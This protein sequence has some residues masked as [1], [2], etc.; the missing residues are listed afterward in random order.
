MPHTQ[1]DFR[2]CIFCRNHTFKRKTLADTPIEFTSHLQDASAEE[3]ENDRLSCEVS[4]PGQ[5]V[6]WM[7]GETV[8]SA[9][10]KYQTHSEEFQHSLTIRNAG[11]SDAANVT[12]K[13]GSAESTAM[14]DVSGETRDAS[15]KNGSLGFDFLLNDPDWTYSLAETSFYVVFSWENPL[16]GAACRANCDGG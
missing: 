14:P 3:T 16:H 10:E 5:D 13:R 7:T 2:G 8:V 6:T 11:A 4:K 15:S 1:I 12:V 9:A